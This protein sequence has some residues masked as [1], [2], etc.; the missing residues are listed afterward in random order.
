[1]DYGAH[2]VHRYVT[3]SGHCYVSRG[4]YCNRAAFDSWPAA[5]QTAMQSAVR[6]SV[7]A[8]RKL[9]VEEEEIARKA[10]EDAGCEIVALT[11]YERAA[12]VRAVK[13]L[14][15][16]ARQRFGNEMFA[17]LETERES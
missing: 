12:F 16:E 11:P 4:I 8:Q 7:T 5:L 10:L 15:E 3:L 1:M 13:P 9:A 14:H 2:K 17:L 6:E